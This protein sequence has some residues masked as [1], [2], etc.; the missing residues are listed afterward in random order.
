MYKRQGRYRIEAQ[1]GEG[2]MGVVYKATHVTLNKTLALKVLRGE[3]AKDPEVVQRFMQEAQAATSIGHEN[4]I[5]INDFGSLKDGTAYFVMEYLNGH[6]LADLIKRGGSIP[7]RDAIQILRQVAGALGAAHA[8]GIVHRDLK[9]DNVFVLPRGE[10]ENDSTERAL[11]DTKRQRIATNLDRLKN[12]IQTTD[13]LWRS[14][15]AEDAAATVRRIQTFARKSPVKEFELLDIRSLLQDAVEITRTRW[16]N[17]AP[18]LKPW[19]PR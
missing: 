2:G 18:V 5:D 7:M 9:P 3:V 16:Q 11:L 14:T 8:R 19:Q 13:S 10:I 15:A 4:I 12:R 17:E 6:P 1:I